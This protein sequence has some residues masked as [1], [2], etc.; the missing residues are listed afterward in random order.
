MS[1][2]KI[3]KWILSQIPVSTF[4][5]ISG[6]FNHYFKELWKRVDEH[7]LFL[8]GG[9]IAFSLL[10]SLLPLLLVLISVL[11]NILNQSTIE[12]QISR[13]IDTLIPYPAY[14]DYTKKV[15][16]TRIPEV[17]EYKTIA[18]Y[19]GVIGL[20]FTSTWLFSSMRTILNKIFG[21]TEEKSAWIGL[22]RDLGMVLL[23]ILLISLSTVILPI[24][25]IFIE[26][27]EKNEILSMFRFSEMVDIGL[28]IF[29]LLLLYGMFFFLYYLVPY[30]KLGKRVPAISAFWTVLFWEIAR[31][32]FG[33]YV[34]Y[35]LSTNNIYGAFLLFIVVLFWIFYSSCLFIVGAEIG[36]LYRE[37]REMKDKIYETS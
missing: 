7:H 20:L 17:I 12:I 23:V 13:V 6:F 30:E 22:L 15:I 1:R 4:R 26:S 14:A 28:K 25:N 24:F 2:F 11:G 8:S 31:S 37:R 34:K 27:A 16:L 32:I 3:L 9:G 35:F 29:T 21:V 5:K 10:L 19:A 18:G 36:Q 33:Y